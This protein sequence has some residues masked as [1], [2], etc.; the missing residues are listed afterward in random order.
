M[1]R[2]VQGQVRMKHLNASGRWPSGNRRYYFRPPGRKNTPLPDL[3]PDHPDFY[4]AYV[5]AANGDKPEPPLPEAGTIASG[6][7]AFMRSDGY[8]TLAPST[9][10]VWRRYLDALRDSYGTG[11]MES[12]APR[13]IRQDIAQFSAHPANNRLKVWRSMCKWWLSVGQ[14]ETNPA[15]DVERRPTPKAQGATPWTRED[16]QTFRKRWPVGS[17]ERLA[18]ELMYQS[19]AA[20]GDMTRLGPG[21]VKDGWLSY[22]R[23][24]S[25]STATCPWTASAPTWFEGSTD[26]RRCLQIAP[27]GITFLLTSHTRP[28]SAKA[29]AQWFSRACTDAELPSHSAHGIR[30]G[31]AAMFKENAASA[32]Q[33]MAILGHETE[34]EAM[35]YSKSA[36]LRKIITGTEKFQLLEKRPTRSKTTRKTK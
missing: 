30:K 27:K 22:T 26:L 10:L 5:T 18:F 9:R 29:A 33:H 20:V 7:V 8:L 2:S 24:K 6:I 17:A 34:S 28:K 23:Q 25:G 11:T 19:C 35:H 14:I 31:R 21:N 13:H 36:D 3:P 32:D 1:R 15:R 12:L 16:F 4:A